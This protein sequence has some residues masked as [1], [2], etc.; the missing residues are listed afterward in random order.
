MYSIIDGLLDLFC[1]LIDA[2]HTVHLFDIIT[3]LNPVGADGTIPSHER[4]KNM[5]EIEHIP[6]LLG[7]LLMID[8]V[9]PVQKIEI[10]FY[11]P[12][13]GPLLF[14]VVLQVGNDVTDDTELLVERGKLAG[15]IKLNEKDHAGY[16]HR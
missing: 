16:Y 3:V 12:D 5:L 9:L 10:A 4:V 1:R 2:L 15:N 6:H 8:L 13:L 14:V 7:L 11:L